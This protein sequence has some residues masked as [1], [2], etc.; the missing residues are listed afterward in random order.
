V[1]GNGMRNKTTGVLL[2]V[3]DVSIADIS[4]NIVV[5]VMTLIRIVGK[6]F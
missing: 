2:V 3:E 1:Q 4:K 5:E 6:S